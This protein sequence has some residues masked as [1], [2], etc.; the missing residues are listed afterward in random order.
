MQHNR[1]LLSLAPT[2]IVSHCAEAF[3][4]NIICKIEAFFNK[5]SLNIY[6]KADRFLYD[7]LIKRMEIF[8]FLD[9]FHWKVTPN[10]FSAARFYEKMNI[11]LSQ[12]KDY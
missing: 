4:Y 3:S 11:F 12:I 5:T 2:L 1:K 10:I 8:M 9:K 7:F 6:Q